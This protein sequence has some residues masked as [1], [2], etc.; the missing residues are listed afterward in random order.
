MGGEDSVCGDRIVVHSSR[1]SLDLDLADYT[2]S[3]HSRLGLSSCGRNAIVPW[4]P[5]TRLT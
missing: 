2:K 3:D 1:P 5:S 4:E